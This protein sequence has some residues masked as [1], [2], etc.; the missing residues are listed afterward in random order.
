MAAMKPDKPGRSM[1]VE[2]CA[3]DGALA[4]RY[5]LPEQPGVRGLRLEEEHT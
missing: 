4:F 2:A 1:A 3:Y 5:A